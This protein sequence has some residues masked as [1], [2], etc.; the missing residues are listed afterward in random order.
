M[1]TVPEKQFAWPNPGDEERFYRAMYLAVD[2][3]KGRA[4]YESPR[5]HAIVT[6]SGSIEDTRLI[7][8]PREKL[9]EMYDAAVEARII[10]RRQRSGPGSAAST[11]NGHQCQATD[12]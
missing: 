3:A 12:L 9:L 10:G 2:C 6:A 11:P 1:A 4:S 8:S 5:Y 7:E